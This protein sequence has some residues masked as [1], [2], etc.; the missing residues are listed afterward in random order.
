M[1]TP[2]EAPAR[3]VARSKV[4]SAT[5]YN[6]RIPPHAYQSAQ[7]LLEWRT[8]QLLYR[9]IIAACIRPIRGRMCGGVRVQNHD[10]QGLTEGASRLEDAVMKNGCTREDV[11]GQ[12]A[13]THTPIP[14][15]LVACRECRGRSDSPQGCTCNTRDSSSHSAVMRVRMSRDVGSRAGY[16]CCCDRKSV[17]HPGSHLCTSTHN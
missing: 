5:T 7:L 13:N 1:P 10:Q 4:A 16:M 12:Q 15:G 17:R 11:M 3:A 8:V 9:G 2:R 6:T 14:A